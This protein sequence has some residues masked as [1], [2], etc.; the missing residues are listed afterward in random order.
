MFSF[1]KKINW[2]T[3]GEFVP[4]SFLA[5]FSMI[6]VVYMIYALIKCVTKY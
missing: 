6:V 3:V 4:W 2:T 1:L 5:F